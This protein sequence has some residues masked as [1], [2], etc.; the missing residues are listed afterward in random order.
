MTELSL[1]E[2]LALFLPELLLALGA[3]A[4]LMLGV[5]QREES[6]RRIA[7][8]A[9]ALTLLAL[10]SA[11]TLP[12]ERAEIFGGSFVID[13][14]AITMKALAL[15][16]VAAAL[17]IGRAFSETQRVG[18]FEYPILILLSAVGILLMISANDLIALYIGIETQSL[19][20]YVLAAWHRD[21][22]KSSEAGLKYFILGALSSGILLYGCSMIYGFGGG[23]GFAE[24]AA[25]PPSA[26]LTIGCVFALSG[27]AFKISAVPF[28]MWTPD[29]YEGAPTPVALFLASAPKVAALALIA[30]FTLEALPPHAGGE[31]I[32][33]ILAIGSMILGA[34]A[35]IGQANLKRLLAYSA[36]GHMGYALIGLIAGGEEG[37]IALVVYAGIYLL[38]IIGV[39]CSLMALRAE[40]RA[41]QNIE[42]LTGL[43]QTQ[44]AMAFLLAALLFSLAGI[45]PLAGFF[46]KFYVFLSAIEQGFVWLAVIGVVA[47]VIASYYYLRIIKLMYFDD[48]DISLRME[49]S[50]SS[51]FVLYASG[52]FALGFI[53][54]PRLL[55]EPAAWAARGL[56][57]LP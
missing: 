36:I 55:S 53:L 18:R 34:V 54:A 2:Q 46:G 3:M 32:L 39:F 37:L 1:T 42:E 7:N 29:V 23:I 6:G 15:I 9:I 28:H 19:A 48:P 27:L 51:R 57:G 24:I 44:P 49:L 8:L 16:G 38:T 4:L 12:T 30:R 20:L 17:L 26:G 35:A 25:A 33:T 41:P 22:V 13:S 45:P 11:L 40:T 43:S 31:D 10:L 52:V 14:F 50:P 5:F 56:L 21:S 47:S